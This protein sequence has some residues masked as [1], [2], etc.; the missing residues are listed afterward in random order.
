[1]N[2]GRLVAAT[3]VRHGVSSVFTLCGGHISPILVEAKRA[4]LGVLDVRH[5]VD[6]VFAADAVGRLT[7]TPGVAAVT[8]GPGAT[9]TITAVKNA[10]LAQSPVVILGGATATVLEGRGS[11]QDI[12][13]MA[14]FRPHVK[15]LAGVKRVRDLAPAL[16]EALTVCRQGVPGPVF[17]SAHSICCTRRRSSESGT[18]SKAAVT[19]AF[20]VG[21]CRAT[22]NGT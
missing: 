13:Q 16:D 4:G 11:L 3:L 15:W 12:D 6:A 7:G 9:N 1:M 18:D 21:S 19:A 22:S 17:W 5:E 10:Q 8:A 2:G 20:A 14:L